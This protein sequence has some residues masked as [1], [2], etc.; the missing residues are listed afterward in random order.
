MSPAGLTFRHSSGR[1]HP[2][3]HPR[4]DLVRVLNVAG[5][6][7][8][9]VGGVQADALAI[10]RGGVVDHLVHVRRTEI[11]ARAGS[12]GLAPFEPEYFPG[13]NV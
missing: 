5:L 11:L 7:M 8:H 12:P 3:V 10:R 2:P 1:R 9:A 4:D 6:A 13:T